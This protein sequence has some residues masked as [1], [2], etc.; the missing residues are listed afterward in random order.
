MPLGPI[1][2]RIPPGERGVLL[3]RTWGRHL[4]AEIADEGY[5]E[6]Q[7]FSW[8]VRQ[9]QRK[10]S[11]S[12]FAHDVACSIAAERH[13]QDVG[14]L[15]MQTIKNESALTCQAVQPKLAP[16]PVLILDEQSSKWP[17]ILSVWLD[18]RS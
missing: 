9:R 12:H 8:M 13:K 5:P 2:I 14:P 4:T 15:A 17:N 18:S 11:R 1:Q 10:A 3:W 6:R 16:S 7:R